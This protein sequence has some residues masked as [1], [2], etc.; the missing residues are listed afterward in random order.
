M[1]SASTLPVQTLLPTHLA[2]NM[3][4]RDALKGVSNFERAGKASGGTRQPAAQIL[5]MLG[6]VAAI[7]LCAL[8]VAH[9]GVPLRGEGCVTHARFVPFFVLFSAL[10]KSLRLLSH[11][12]P[13]SSFARIASEARE[14]PT[15][16]T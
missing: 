12:R 16:K 2:Y 15:S 3:F 6:A 14:G 5:K 11:S 9:A 7:L 10:R 8:A 13:S 4:F 1:L